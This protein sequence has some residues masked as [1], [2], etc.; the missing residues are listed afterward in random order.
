MRGEQRRRDRERLAVEMNALNEPSEAGWRQFAPMLD[1]AMDEMDE[2]D[3]DALVLRYFEGRELRAVGA[4]L[5]VSDDTAQK[6]VDRALEKLH[7]LLK[8]RGATLPAAALGTALATEAVTAAPAGLA[9]S[10]AGAA[11]ASAAAG[12]GTAATLAKL[13]T[14]TKLK[15]SIL[16]V[17]AVAGVATPLA[18]QQQ[19][20]ARLRQENQALRQQASEVDQMAA[21]NERLSNLVVQ[22][23]GSASLSRDQLSELLRLRGEAGGLRR[24]IKE[25]EAL[26]AENR[27]LR[28]RLAGVPAVTVARDAKAL[29]PEDEARNVCGNNLREIDRAIQQC[30]LENKLAADD[31]VTAQQ[32]L[33]YLKDTNV[34]SCPL[35]GT[36]TFG[37]AG[38][39]PSCSMPDHVLVPAGSKPVAVSDGNNTFYLGATTIN[40]TN[41]SATNVTIG[42]RR[43]EGSK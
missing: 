33:P 19:S 9:G 2:A 28:T 35:G 15:V 1:Q 13:M 8:H 37:R 27:Q 40:G 11:L 21:E 16:S 25:L 7:V 10:V 24:Q 22:A 3:R 39:R 41:V 12:G 6:R 34:M 26:Q 38:D 17:I 20:Q 30:A 32:I 42:V 23:K 31:M 4:A 14:M 5:G 29:S 18:I 36:Y 43:R